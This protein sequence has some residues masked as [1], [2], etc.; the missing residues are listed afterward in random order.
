MATLSTNV[1]VFFFS[2]SALVFLWSF[3]RDKEWTQLSAN[4]LAPG[5]KAAAITVV[6]FLV[7]FAA[8]QMGSMTVAPAVCYFAPALIV[9][10]IVSRLNFLRGSADFFC[11]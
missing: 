1:M 9:P 6:P 11:L 4:A 8:A 3:I 10:F 5:L 2:V 7:I